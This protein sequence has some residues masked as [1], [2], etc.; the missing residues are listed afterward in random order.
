MSAPFVV[1]VQ[2]GG[3]SFFNVEP[4]G[5]FDEDEAEALAL[6]LRRVY[7]LDCR[8]AR[9]KGWTPEV[10]DRVVSQEGGRR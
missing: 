6:H 8:A 1:L 7:G 9:L 3:R 10:E 2:H 5:P 4:Y